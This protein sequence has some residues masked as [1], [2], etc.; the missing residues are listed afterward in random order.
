[1]FFAITPFMQC[2]NKNNNR[3]SHHC[4]KSIRTKKRIRFRLKLKR[5]LNVDPKS[6]AFCH[7]VL[8][9]IFLDTNCRKIGTL[10]IYTEDISGKN[11]LYVCPKCV[12]AQREDKNAIVTK[13][14]DSIDILHCRWERR[15][16]KKTYPVKLPINKSTEGIMMPSL[17]A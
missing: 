14:I 12:Y 17:A 5:S 2:T 15:W 9:L 11:Y 1:M 16:F 6:C 4:K 8:D 13:T 3:T 7:T 10:R